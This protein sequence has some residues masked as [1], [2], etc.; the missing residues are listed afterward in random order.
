MGVLLWCEEV[1]ARD[2]WWFAGR[3]PLPWLLNSN[4]KSPLSG[5]TQLITEIGLH[6]I[7]KWSLKITVFKIT[8]FIIRFFDK[9]AL[10]KDKREY[11]FVAQAIYLCLYCLFSSSC[12]QLCPEILHFP[13]LHAII[14]SNIS[15][16]KHPFFFISLFHGEVLN[17]TGPGST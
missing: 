6:P 11:C 9:Y 5:W 13:F 8:Y 7:V 4:R 2:L 12:G 14:L 15:E 3:P 16:I 1:L 10:K 17:M